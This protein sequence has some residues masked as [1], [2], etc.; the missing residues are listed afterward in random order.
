MLLA[1]SAATDYA[2]L[3]QH[4]SPAFVALYRRPGDL[5]AQP[6]NDRFTVRPNAW[7][8]VGVDVV[9]DVGQQQRQALSLSG[10]LRQPSEHLPHQ[11]AAHQ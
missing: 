3:D 11:L 1:L 2:G 4:V 5:A 6:G 9:R 10:Y 8:G 7:L